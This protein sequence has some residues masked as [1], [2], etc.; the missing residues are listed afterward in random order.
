MNMKVEVSKLMNH[1]TDTEF[2]PKEG[3]FADTQ[4]VKDRVLAQAAP[5]RR[6]KRAGMKLMLV[7]AAAVA[8]VGLMAAGLPAQVYTM[9]TGGTVVAQ[10]GTGEISI[11][12]T[13]DD[14]VSP[15]TAENGRLWFTADGQHV[16]ITGLI[17][18][19]TPYIYTRTDPDTGS[20]GYIIVGGTMDDLGYVELTSMDGVLACTGENYFTLDGR[21]NAW[22]ELPEEDQGDDSEGW[23]M[24]Y[25]EKP[26]Y[27][28]AKEQLNLAD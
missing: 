20:I 23:S 21:A 22:M 26:W 15:V 7:A 24:S 2:C 27:I 18:E 17:D 8:C 14:P 16:D 5:A 10:S 3:N 4:A 19:N 28:A 1:Y 25:A 12:L 9:F 11:G 13:G 6:G